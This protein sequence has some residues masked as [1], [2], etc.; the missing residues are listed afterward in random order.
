VSDAAEV[1]ADDV[2]DVDDAPRRLDA[3]QLAIHLGL[4]AAACVTTYM[5]NGVAFAATLMAILVC[6]ELGHYFAARYHGVDVSL[7]YFIPLPPQVSLG[8]LGA[9]IKMRRPIAD[10]DKLFDVGAAGPIAGLCVAIPALVVGLAIS[11]VGPIPPDSVLEGNSILYGVLKLAILGE[12]VPA[13]GVDVQLHPIGFAAW[14]GLL[15]TFINLIPIGQLDGGHVAR[16]AF[17]EAHDRISRRLHVALPLVGVLSGATLFAL[18]MVAGRDVVGSLRYASY[19]LLPWSIWGLMLLAMHRMSGGYHPPT[20]ARPL[21][22]G[23]R[24]VAIGLL[25]VFFLI[26]MPVPMRP[27]L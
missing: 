16:A 20:H 1:E 15:V 11:D 27:P 8:T 9:V 6:H 13:N 24:R 26:F 18:A 14:V 7:P 12:W 19:G 23:R 10:P 3:K 2:D 5:F 21:S 4:F 25:I 22:P 17:G